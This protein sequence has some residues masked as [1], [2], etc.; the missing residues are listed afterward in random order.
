MTESE[1]EEQFLAVL[2]SGGGP[3]EELQLRAMGT[4]YS[5]PEPDRIE[6]EYRAALSRNLSFGA[7]EFPQVSRAHFYAAPGDTVAKADLRAVWSEVTGLRGALTESTE[8]TNKLWSEVRSL[9]ESLLEAR[10]ELVELHARNLVADLSKKKAAALKTALTTVREQELDVRRG[11]LNF[12]HT[13]NDSES[14]GRRRRRAPDIRQLNLEL[15]DQWARRFKVDLP[16]AAVQL[17]A[18]LLLEPSGMTVAH[19]ILNPSAWPLARPL[20]MEPLRAKPTAG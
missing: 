3:A 13:L 19:A 15:V 9:K 7:V 20:G 1:A 8:L 17:L 11:L 2:E 16:V 4:N 12:L 6:Q 10:R 5:W 18:E 14:G